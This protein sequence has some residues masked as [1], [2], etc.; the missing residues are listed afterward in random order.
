VSKIKEIISNKHVL[1]K[2]GKFC[3]IE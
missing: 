3:K 2:Y 1:W